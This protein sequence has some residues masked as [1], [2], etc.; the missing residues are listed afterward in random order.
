[1]A[2]SRDWLRKANP[3][4]LARRK[5]AEMATRKAALE[6]LRDRL[7]QAIIGLADDSRMGT[8]LRSEAKRVERLLGDPNPPEPRFVW[9]DLTKK[10]IARIKPATDQNRRTACWSWFE[11]LSNVETRDRNDLARDLQRRGV[12]PAPSAPGSF[13][14]LSTKNAGCQGMERTTGIGRVCTR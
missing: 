13:R 4:L 1:M 2:V 8:F 14:R 10:E 7:K 9:L 5:I 6:Q 3:E 12:D 11:R